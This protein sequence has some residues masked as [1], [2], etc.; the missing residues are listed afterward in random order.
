MLGQGLRLVSC[1]IRKRTIGAIS[2]W[3]STKAQKNDQFDILTKSLDQPLSSVSGA[4][5][6]DQLLMD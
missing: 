3:I 5:G 6:E 2:T 1:G 4:T